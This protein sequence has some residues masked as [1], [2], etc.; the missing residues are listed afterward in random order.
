MNPP[1]NA[2][3]RNVRAKIMES[4][5]GVVVERMTEMSVAITP[6]RASAYRMVCDVFS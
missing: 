5:I 4:S 1:R 3:H 6:T 2:A